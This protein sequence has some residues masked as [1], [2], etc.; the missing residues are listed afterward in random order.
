MW[1]GAHGRPDCPGRVHETLPGM[2]ITGL[3][4]RP[5]AAG[6]GLG[7]PASELRDLRV[8]LADVWGSEGSWLAER[9][10]TADGRGGRLS[11]LQEVADERLRQGPQRDPLVRAA[12]GMLDRVL[13]F[14]RFLDQAQG[15]GESLARCAAQLGYADQ[16]H[17]AR[18][19]RE[20]SGL[21]PRDLLAS[22]PS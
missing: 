22:W 1:L 5:G 18:S 6:V 9:L 13:R 11:L 20:L 8:P 17:L 7:L 15:R 3:R 12:I 10:A 2:T 19:V 16:A 4:F 14:R 21:A